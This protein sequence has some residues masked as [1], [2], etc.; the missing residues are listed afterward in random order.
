MAD[1]ES[2]A[3]MFAIPDLWQSSK[4]LDQLDQADDATSPFFATEL[5][6]SHDSSL[7]HLAPVAV[8]KN[9]FFKLPPLE[10][11]NT[12]SPQADETL[13]DSQTTSQSTPD[14]ELA[15]DV[16]LSLDKVPEKSPQHRT[17]DA[18]LSATTATTQLPLITEAGPATYDAILCWSIDPLKLQNSDVP[19]VEAKT[20]FSSLL[21]L[22]IGQESVF[23]LR[24]DKTKSFAS[25]LPKMRISGYSRHVLQGLEKQCLRCGSIFLE[26][27]S[28][29]QSTYSRRSTRCGVALAS[30]LDQV[31]KD[32]Q[33]HV[34]VH[35]HN[36]RSLLGLQSTIKGLLAILEPF[37]RLT[38]KLRRGYSDEDVLSIVFHEAYSVDHREEQLREIM[39]EVLGRVSRPWIDFLE[40]WI[41]TRREQGIPFTKSSVGESKGFVKVETEIYMDDFGQQVE[42]VDFRLDDAKMPH[43]MPNDI[44][45]SIFETGKNLRFI[46]SCHPEHPLANYEI[47]ALTQPP[48]AEWLY[49]WDAILQLESRVS[50]Y[51]DNLLNAIQKSRANS[52]P[53]LQVQETSFALQP[54]AELQFFGVEENKIEE[55]LLASMDQFNQPLVDIDAD[56]SLSR[57]VR[58][59]LSGRYQSPSNSSNFAPHWSLLPVLSFGGITSAQAQVINQESLRLLFTHHD[60]RSHL[61]MHR[62]FQLFGN[63]MFS[64]RLSNALF[65]PDLE[66]AERQA[67]VARQGGVMGLRLGGRDNWPPASSELRLALTGVLAETFESENG[68]AKEKLSSISRDS[69][70]LPGDLSFAVRDLSDEEIDKCMNPDSLEALDFLRLSY[71]PPVPLSSIITPMIL[72]QYDR[73]FKLLLRILRMLYIVNQLFRDVNA[74]TSRWDDPENVSY[75]FPREAHHF[76]S[77]IT[78]YFMDAGVAIPWQEFEAKLDKIQSSLSKPTPKGSQEK[79]QSPDG[80]R[81][82]HSQALDRI[83]VALFLRKRQLPVLNLLEEIFTAVLQYAKHSRLQALGRSTDG[84]GSMSPEELYRKF[85]KKVQIFITVCRGLTEKGRLSNNKGGDDSAPRQ[86]GIGEDHM[87]AQLLMKLDMNDAMSRSS[88]AARNLSLT[89]ELERLEQSITLTLQEIDHNFSKSHRIVTTSILPLVEQYG[90]HSRAVWEASKFWKQFFEASANVSLSG[91]EELAN[92]EETTT[93]EESTAVRDETTVDYTAQHG[94]EDATAATGAEQSSYQLDESLLDDAELSGSTPRPPSTK[95]TK[96]RFSHLESPYETM[97]REMEDEEHHTTVL[98]DG[99]DSTVLFAQHTARLPDMSMTPR[100]RFKDDDQTSEQSTHYNKDPLLHRILDKT[101]RI[102][103][104]PHK[105]AL[106]VSPLKSAQPKKETPAWQDSPMSSPEMAVPK[107]RSEAFMSP[108]KT[109]ARERLAAATQG[110]R[111][112]GVSVQTPATARKTR[113]VF[114]ADESTMTSG[115]QKYEIDWESDE[116]DDDVDL[117]AGMSP[118]KTIQFALPPS[119]LLQT[120]AREASQR[121]VGDIL[122]DAGADPNSSE[123]SPSMVKMNEDILND[124]F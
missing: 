57:V 55:R 41:G 97:K 42:D 103:A 107:L 69:S 33:Q 8:E 99:E 124:S 12:T 96:T 60:L 39:R 89:E 104:T 30:A 51:R 17:W 65:D 49:D 26:L 44:T 79:T 5:K 75:R 71:K 114:A 83:M 43:F 112:P 45:K 119:K 68:F 24:D 91:Y 54:Q 87:V 66:T 67:G 98:E 117:Y 77:G 59:R 93:L 118:P 101:Y 86:D 32:S 52:Q 113:D 47:I 111:T 2:K 37:H 100:D 46:R 4:W 35:R 62:D 22:A 109:K 123:Y 53:P 20:Y 9:G 19:V 10:T 90:D 1:E 25:A 11:P 23:F 72:M 61:K 14:T 28:F 110:P 115:H 34:A 85:K 82:L 78:S 120:P 29:V 18:F 13:D 56:D 88:A 40:E 63:G 106:R 48:R 70:E 102:Q 81:E 105:P 6:E 15:I 36:P 74:R 27:R 31:L 121:I 76:L 38:S 84:D 21:A 94:E 50:E 92:D 73:I 80:L 16:W 64:S 122:L 3:D 58:H 7:L 95:T 116:G 108:M